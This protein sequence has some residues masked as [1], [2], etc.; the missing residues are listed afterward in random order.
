[1][2]DSKLQESK[3][4]AGPRSRRLRRATIG[5]AAAVALVL[6]LYVYP[7]YAR[8]RELQEAIA[9]ADRLDPGWHFDDMEAARAAV[10]DAENSAPV[11]LA[12]AALL[13]NKWGRLVVAR[14]TSLD[15]RLADLPLP[16][17]LD[18]A[19]LQVLRAELAK[20]T[21]A[22]TKARE[23]ADRPRGY[24][25]GKEELIKSHLV[26]A[27]TLVRMLT[28]DALLHSR[29]GD[30]DGA[31]RSC[32]AALNAG[33]S[34]G[35]GV[36]AISQKVRASCGLD[37][38]HALERT[39]ATGTASAK[40]LE[41]MQRLLAE[42]DGEP[43]LLRFFR[44]TRANYFQV[45]E[46]TRTG[47]F[48]RAAYNLRPSI[49]GS[50]ADDLIDR[51]RARGSEAAYLR[52]STALVEIAKLPTETHRERLQQLT[53][54]VQ[55]LPSVIESLARGADWEMLARAS[56]FNGL[57][58]ELR[59]ATAALAAERYRLAEHRWPERLDALVPRY[60]AV[61]PIDPFDGRPLRLRRLPDGLVI[62][63]VGPDQVDDGGR[64]DR[65]HPDQPGTDLGFQLWDEPGARATKVRHPHP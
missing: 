10:P 30:G 41:E 50:T 44:A 6:G 56:A 38:V 25:P 60:L 11:V 13:P 57:H 32:R 61:V 36:A 4:L 26:P 54:P 43:L 20:V 42:E 45:L 16:Q 29:D 21:A 49:L 5:L 63:S 53:A 31:V 18:D 17:F 47:Q 58:A 15:D 14:G 37:A 12:A 3:P 39:L 24:Y 48:D 59:C 19:D 33:R 7:E 62:Y 65:K 40:A 34:I 52:W 51:Q 2:S 28:V 55:P 1:M 64:V 27:H 8:N 46:V 35:D 22:L 23:L 9:E